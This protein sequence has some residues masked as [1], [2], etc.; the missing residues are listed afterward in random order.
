MEKYS[1][2]KVFEAIR[3]QL[4]GLAYR[5]LGTMSEAEDA[6]Q[7]TYIKWQVS[8]DKSKLKNPEAWITAVCTNTCIDILKS[9]QRKRVDYFGPW[10]PE[11]LHTHSE[12]T[13]EDYLALSSSLTTAFLLV[14]ERL[15]P[16]ERAAFLLHEIFGRSYA[17]VAVTL[18]IQEVACRKLVSRARDN[19]G[20]SRAKYTPSLDKQ[21]EYLVAFKRAVT[22]GDESALSAVLTEDIQLRADGGGKVVAASKPLVGKKSVI[23][24]LLQ[25]LHKAWADDHL[26]VEEFNGLLGLRVVSPD[27]LRA[28]VSFGAG[29]NGRLEHIYI[30]RNPDKLDRIDT[31]VHHDRTTGKL[32]TTC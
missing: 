3:P 28:I 9:A 30:V 11:P 13:T 5:L 16:K 19:V 25:V 24:F 8:P 15:S 6:L 29:E 14:L 23:K 32:N 27:G 21:R 10:L 22:T 31:T 12:K 20:E 1:D 7:D 18:G 4:L 26:Y 17:D 2:L